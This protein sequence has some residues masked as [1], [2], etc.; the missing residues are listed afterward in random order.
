[1]TFPLTAILKDWHKNHHKLLANYSLSSHNKSDL[2]LRCMEEVVVHRM[3][4]MDQCV[5]RYK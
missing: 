1:M 2:F 4:A 3:V 5:V